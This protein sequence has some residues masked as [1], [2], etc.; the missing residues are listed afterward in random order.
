[1][2]QKNEFNLTCA[3]NHLFKK[4]YHMFQIP[5]RHIYDVCDNPFIHHM[6]VKFVTQNIYS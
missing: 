4:S 3:V 5:H 2:D 1:M 6:I